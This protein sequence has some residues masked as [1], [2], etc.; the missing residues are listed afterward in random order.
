MTT[1]RVNE[2]SQDEERILSLPSITRTM[3]AGPDEIDEP[4]VVNPNPKNSSPEQATLSLA[5]YTDQKTPVADSTDRED[6]LSVASE[7]DETDSEGLP[8]LL[9]LSG[10]TVS[11]GTLIAATEQGGVATSTSDIPDLDI[12]QLVNVPPG[13]AAEMGSHTHTSPH[14]EIARDQELKH[15]PPAATSHS[16]AS[17]SA[18]IDRAPESLPYHEDNA[19]ADDQL[20]EE[21]LEVPDDQFL[22]QGTD[23]S[24]PE[25]S[26]GRTNL[27]EPAESE[28]SEDPDA[29]Y[30][31]IG[32]DRKYFKH[33][34]FLQYY[35][36]AP[37]YGSVEQDGFGIVS[38]PVDADELDTF[39]ASFGEEKSAINPMEKKTTTKLA[40]KTTEEGI[41]DGGIDSPHSI[42]ATQK[43]SS[44]KRENPVGFHKDEDAWFTLFFEKIKGVVANSSHI[45][46]PSDALTYKL[47]NDFFAG[48]VLKNADG[49][50]LAPRVSRHTGTIYNHIHTR[51]PRKLVDLGEEVL[52]MLEDST[53]GQ[54]Y[55]PVITEEEIQRYLSDG[56][57]IFDDP[58]DKAKN[59]ALRLSEKETRHN[60]TL[61]LTINNKRKREAQSPNSRSSKQK[62]TPTQ[63]PSK[64][65]LTKSAS[66][67]E[68]PSSSGQVSASGQ[69]SS[70]KHKKP[71]NTFSSSEDVPSSAPLLQ[72]PASQGIDSPITGTRA[73]ESQG[74]I[75]DEIDNDMGP[76]KD[77]QATS[78]FGVEDSSESAAKKRDYYTEPDT[79]FKTDM[80]G[81]KKRPIPTD[82]EDGE[83]DRPTKMAKRDT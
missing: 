36:L 81:S 5:S 65:T 69:A 73:P 77:N 34:Y 27:P 50:S 44:K 13:I 29:L 72:V 15:M 10:I 21:E 63:S 42:T 46:M 43:G 24:T 32:V 74:E 28:N 23:Q 40:K 67:P 62:F 83:E 31:D 82:V 54:L 78:D 25:H 11:P 16:T 18:A 17:T 49:Q 58:S 8:V 38:D 80:Q 70:P 3:S 30:E 4:P 22:P 66:S 45:E 19:L 20:V 59:Q 41:E 7:Y 51:G 37:S 26:D 39:A 57:V 2:T 61:R 48:K 52:S 35:G 68:Q 53:D 33:D 64:A 60:K 71:R 9:S 55:V 47:F 12:G 14:S 6:L 79:F 76:D 75:I 56:T 1:N